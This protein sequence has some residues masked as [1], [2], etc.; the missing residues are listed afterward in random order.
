MKLKFLR[1]GF[2]IA[3][4]TGAILMPT[5]EARAA[6][7]VSVLTVSSQNSTAQ[8][9][10]NVLVHTVAGLSNKTIENT[11]KIESNEEIKV[12]EMLSN[13]VFAITG[14]EN[15]LFVSATAQEESES[16]GKVYENSEIHIISQTDDWTE[17]ESGNVKG[18]IK[19][20]NLILGKD[21]VE[22]AKEIVTEV[23]KGVELHTLEQEKVDECFSV[24][25]TK[26]EEAT[27]IAAE[28]AKRRAE[29]VARREAERQAYLA[30][31]QSVVAF[32]KR[33]IGNPYVWGGTSL[34]NGADCSGFV[35]S[36]YANF[37]ISMPR[38]STAMRSA[39]RAVSYSE[40][41]PGDVVCYNGH[42]GI[43]AGNGQ[44]VN[45]IDSAHGIGMSSATYAPIVTIRRM[46]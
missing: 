25:E 38:T 31:G 1:T 21:A 2:M 43:Y 28:E 17:I 27:R 35:K 22:K 13:K 15:Y 23:H 37:G 18:F 39:G 30:K 26:E 9:K 8:V 4:L 10:Q 42:V 45:A 16:V 41:L 32:A 20:E 36:V 24:G 19:T 29:E 14:E 7:P 11:M 6:E 40:I 5:G 34:T 3:T 46:F 33:F 44:I 12:K